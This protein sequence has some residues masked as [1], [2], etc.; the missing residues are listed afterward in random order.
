MCDDTCFR[1]RCLPV[2]LSMYFAISSFRPYMWPS[3]SVILPRPFRGY[4][5]HASL[6]AASTSPD[7]TQSSSSCAMDPVASPDDRDSGGG[8]ESLQYSELELSSDDV[9]D[10]SSSAAS[11]EYRLRSR[12]SPRPPQLS[13]LRELPGDAEAVDGLPV[14]PPSESDASSLRRAVPPS[15]DRTLV[16]TCLDDGGRARCTGRRDADESESKSEMGPGEEGRPG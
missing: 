1:D 8:D 15:G 16:R 5:R 7:H 3:S 6:N 4:I 12:F 14:L 13:C 2:F 11:C 10:G 9:R